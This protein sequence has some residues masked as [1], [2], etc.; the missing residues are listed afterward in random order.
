MPSDTDLTKAKEI[1][2][3]GVPKEQMPI[4]NHWADQGAKKGMQH[5]NIDWQEHQEA[6]DRS[7]LPA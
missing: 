5:H 6:D 2:A 1:K 4:G 7:P 3:R